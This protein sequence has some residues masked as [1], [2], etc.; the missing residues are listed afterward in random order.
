MPGTIIKFKY[1][2]KDKAGAATSR[3]VHVNSAWVEYDSIYFRG[4]C[5][6]RNDSRTFRLDRVEGSILNTESGEVTYSKYIY[7]PKMLLSFIDPTSNQNKKTSINGTS[8]EPIR[9]PQ[10]IR[11]PLNKKLF[12]FGKILALIVF[13]ILFITSFISTASADYC[14]TGRYSIITHNFC[15]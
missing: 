3:I 2:D 9:R 11:S 12:S 4:Y 8:P 6:L 15:G 13:L 7:N 10:A 1:K 14:A 5:E